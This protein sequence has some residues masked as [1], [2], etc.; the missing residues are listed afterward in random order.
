MDEAEAFDLPPR[1][2]IR[3]FAGKVSVGTTRWDDVWQAAHS[4]AFMVAGVQADDV[5][6]GVRAALDKALAEGTTLAQFRRDL[7]PLMQR[8]GW[9]EKGRG[10]AAW[11]TRLVYET[12]LRGAYAAG[13]YEQQT[14]PDVLPLVPIWR[15]R[16]SGAKDARPEHL[17]WD[18]LTLRHDDPWWA[19]H[20][21]PNGWGC[22]CWVEPMTE[23]QAA[24]DGG[25]GSA[26]EILRRRWTD[27]A[28]GRTDMVPLGID[29]GWDYNVGAAWREARDLPGSTARMPPDG[30]PDW[31]PPAP[32]LQ[33]VASLPRAPA[34]MMR[35]EIRRA[36]ARPSVL[37]QD[38]R[39]RDAYAPW[40]QALTPEDAQAI[41]AY[42]SRAGATLN[43]ILRGE[44]AGAPPAAAMIAR[45]ATALAAARTP[46]A[47]TVHRGAGAAALAEIGAV[48]SDGRFTTFISTSIDIAVA[49]DFAR[50]RDGRV[51]E[52]RLPAGL[53]GAAYIQMSTTDRPRQYELL[54]APGLGYRV[55]S[56]TGRRIVLEVFNVWDAARDR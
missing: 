10:Y 40:R 50:R 7:K 30:P 41:S 19:S 54:L 23:A 36:D 3:F 32:V 43:R 22:G 37:A 48:G 47:I 16:H 35:T 1:E 24:R 52:L 46:R 55:I 28:S 26:P 17:R 20:Y 4:R 31:P 33:R 45:L 12:N 21:P 25:L 56:R 51:V 39:L 2:A 11:R 8:L 13:Q 6:G 18:G 34:A 53:N 9:E 49:T 15:Y 29:P 38:A 44:R 14:D 5:L 42:R 27:P